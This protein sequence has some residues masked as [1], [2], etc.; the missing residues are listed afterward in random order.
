M[1]SIPEMTNEQLDKLIAERRGEKV[2][3]PHKENSLFH[4]T[5]IPSYTTDPRY[6]MKLLKEMAE[7]HCFG[8]LVINIDKWG[9][10]YKSGH[11]TYKRVNADT[12]E[13]AIAEAWMEW[14]K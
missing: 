11:N 13:R 3:L 2:G 9:V 12:P 1:T 10:D 14:A 5:V 8:G 6:A 7:G 4:F